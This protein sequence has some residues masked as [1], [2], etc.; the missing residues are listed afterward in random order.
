V[1]DLAA[2]LLDTLDE[3][4]LDRLAERL[5]P[6]L[7]GRLA[8]GTPQADGWLTSREAAAH[9]GVSLH[10]LHR[11]SADRRIPAS[12][13]RPGGRLYFRRSELDRWRSERSR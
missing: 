12:Q 5:A 6:R 2:A 8:A 11:L 9:L 7:A 10:A 4:A 1:T 3:D 13:D